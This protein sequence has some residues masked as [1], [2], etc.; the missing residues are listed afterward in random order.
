M[1]KPPEARDALADMDLDLYDPTYVEETLKEI[2]QG[3]E[4]IIKKGNPLIPFRY[5]WK[6]QADEDQM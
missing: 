3:R 5:F 6:K 2:W 4:T 1:T